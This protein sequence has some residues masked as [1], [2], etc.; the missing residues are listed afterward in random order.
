M[1]QQDYLLRMIM[2]FAEAIRQSMQKAQGEHD[3]RIAAEMLET[4]VG[5]AT[6]IDGSIL[7][8]LAPESMVQ[9]MQVSGTDNHLIGYIAH[10][11][12][13][14]SL[15]L[16]EANEPGRAKLREQQ[17]RAVAS[18]YGIALPESYSI[19]EMDAFLDSC[20]QPDC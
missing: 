6:D 13:L 18:A 7:L 17:A 20:E 11:L 10:S 2:Q 5:E 19:A 9:I 1:L 16:Q 14:S 12:L 3:P 8:G 15:Y 4:A